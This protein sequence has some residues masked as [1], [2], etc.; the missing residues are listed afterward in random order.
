MRTYHLID[1]AK[2]WV[3]Q[4]PICHKLLGR[5][6][7][8]GERNITPAKQIFT[9]HW[10]FEMPEKH[11]HTRTTVFYS[12]LSVCFPFKHFKQISVTMPRVTLAER[13]AQVFLLLTWPK[14]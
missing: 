7:K 2:G 5:A 8:I 4:H 11:P 14:A 3:P 10:Y 13:R 1:T 6:G 12:F 9:K